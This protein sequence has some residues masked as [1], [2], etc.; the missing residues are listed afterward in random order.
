[1]RPESKIG[2]KNCSLQCQN[3]RP[4]R[5]AHI[6]TS[7]DQHGAQGMLLRLAVSMQGSRY[8]SHVFSLTGPG[9]V[10]DKLLAAGIPVTT[11]QLKGNIHF[12]LEL[13]KLA[14]S[15]HAFRPDIVQTWMYHADLIGGLIVSLLG[16]NNI[17]WNVR[18]SDVNEKGIRLLTKIITRVCAVLSHVLP[19]AIIC[20]SRRACTIHE[21]IGYRKDKFLL[22]PNGFDLGVFKSIPDAGSTLRSL[23]GLKE[24]DFLV[25]IAARFHPQKD[26]HGLIK[27]AAIVCAKA[28]N[29]HFVLCGNGID[30][31]NL[32]LSSWI[33]EFGLRNY[34]H[35][36]GF[37]P[38]VNRITAGFDVALLPSAYGEGF[39]NALGEAMASGIPCVTTDVG[40]SAWIV[41]D[42]GA[43]VPPSNPEA[44]AAAIMEM[45]MLPKE[46]LQRLGSK[47]RKRIET[48]FSLDA[49]VLLYQKAYETVVI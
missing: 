23:L 27:S 46:E 9:D 34:F 15:I 35:L 5:V 17:F 41:N 11:V 39:S 18:H 8:S 10:G 16:I 12:L 25:G 28:S 30:Q 3:Q 38:D 37:R 1:M 21:K 14:R 36:L 24:T 49:I 33:D 19:R 20:N 31:N 32:Q 40:D 29:V 45:A 48:Q 7:L 42:T 44:L 6:I 26:H 43:V 2:L 22:I 13:F 4:L 47:A